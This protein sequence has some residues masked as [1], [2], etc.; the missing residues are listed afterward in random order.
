MSISL[1]FGW[2]IA[3]ESHL[4]YTMALLLQ[5]FAV[6]APIG[7]KKGLGWRCIYEF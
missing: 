5:E 3:R 2:G 4:A 6:E 1:I 7:R